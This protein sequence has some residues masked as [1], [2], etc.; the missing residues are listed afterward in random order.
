MTKKS[1]LQTDLFLFAYVPDWYDKLEELAKTAI[2]E[3]WRF[4][5]PHSQTKNIHTPILERYIREIFRMQATAYNG[6]TDEWEKMNA[7][8]ISQRCA[9][10]HTG[11]FTQEYKP[12]Y[13]CFEPNRRADSMLEWHLQGFADDNSVWLKHAAPLP[14]APLAGK[15]EMPGYNP[16]WSIRANMKHILGDSENQSRIPEKL[17]WIKYL[18]LLMETAME[19]GRRQAMIEPGIVV[20]QMYRGR[21]QYLL[22]ISLSDPDKPDLAMTLSIMEGYYQGETCLTLQMAYLNARLLGRPIVRWLAELVE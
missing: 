14:K 12:I 4:K 2:K 5:I 17:R 3:P 9:C 6:A 18:P 13:A 7:L 8:H 19:L 10:F 22:P 1:Y 21:A 11:L 16:G 20:P 15:A